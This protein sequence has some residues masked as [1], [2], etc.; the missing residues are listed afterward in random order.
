MDLHSDAQAVY[1]ACRDALDSSGGG[2]GGG[3]P[4]W[5]ALMETARTMPMPPSNL[6]TLY[7]QLLACTLRCVLKR[8]RLRRR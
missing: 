4:T 2:G 6:P 8:T 1:S 7:E 5:A 3:D